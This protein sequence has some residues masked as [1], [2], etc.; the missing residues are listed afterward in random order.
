MDELRNAVYQ[1]AL[2]YIAHTGAYP[3]VEKFDED[4]APIGPR[5]RKEMVA[6]GLLFEQHG[7]LVPYS[8]VPTSAAY[9]RYHKAL[10]A[11]GF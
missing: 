5:L 10:D 4:H 7:R 9:Q 3:T 11:E 2:D 8:D 6:V 1:K